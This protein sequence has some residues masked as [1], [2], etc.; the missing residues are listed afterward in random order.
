MS[1]STEYHCDHCHRDTFN[2]YDWWEY[3]AGSGERHACPE[4]E[5]EMP[6]EVEYRRKVAS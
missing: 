1:T 3:N 6:E 2:P 4:C 5:D